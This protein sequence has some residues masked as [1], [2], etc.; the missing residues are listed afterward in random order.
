[1]SRVLVVY[2]SRTG[3]TETVARHIAT[4]CGADLEAIEDTPGLIGRAG[5]LGYVRSS[6]E[7]LLGVEP[8][9]R[10][11]HATPKDYD[12]V[13]VGTPV[14]FWNMSSPVRSYLVRHRAEIQKVAF[15]CTLGGSGQDKVMA[16]LRQLCRKPPVATLSLTTQQV[17]ANQDAQA[18]SKFVSE[19]RH[20]RAVA[21]MRGPALAS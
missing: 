20:A 4:Q 5:L 13:I 21:H 18:V 12:L 19:L 14:W 7:A 11:A 1:M 15:F 9:I 10:R 2:F 3:H 6:L 17:E 8:P 16:D